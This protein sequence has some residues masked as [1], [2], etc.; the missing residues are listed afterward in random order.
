MKIKKVIQVILWAIVV[1]WAVNIVL[2]LLG[3]DICLFTMQSLKWFELPG[4]LWIAYV[5]ATSGLFA[6]AIN[7]LIATLSA[8]DEPSVPSENKSTPV[9]A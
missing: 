7:L 1:V 6:I 5:C 8:D 3:H 4:R 2:L 9:N